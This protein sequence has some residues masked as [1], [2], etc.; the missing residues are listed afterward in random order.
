LSQE[1]GP[2]LTHVPSRWNIGAELR[3]YLSAC[4]AA[5][6]APEL[7]A[8]FTRGVKS[9]LLEPNDGAHL[10]PHQCAS[11]GVGGGRIART[12]LSRRIMLSNGLPR[13]LLGAVSMM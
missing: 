12:S 1:F 5:A 10:W 9:N 4:E 11:D 8:L 7:D 6:H 2:C 3:N 13:L